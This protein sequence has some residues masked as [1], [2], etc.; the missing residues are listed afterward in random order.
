MSN[1]RST[2]RIARKGAVHQSSGFARVFAIPG[3]AKS[4]GHAVFG[5]LASRF[6]GARR[7]A[8]FS[9]YETTCV[10]ACSGAAFA[11]P[12]ADPGSDQISTKSR[13]SS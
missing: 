11:R 5:R 2:S 7:R 9:T 12:A 8:A 10:G 13:P 1:N 6:V 3:W 4:V